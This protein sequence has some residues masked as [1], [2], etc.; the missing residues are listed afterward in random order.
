ME[1]IVGETCGKFGKYCVTTLSKAGFEE[2]FSVYYWLP[3]KQIK[4]SV[5]VAPQEGS[6]RWCLNARFSGYYFVGQCQKMSCAYEPTML[7]L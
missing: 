3:R 5:T 2:F 7:N 1:G 4:I 6:D